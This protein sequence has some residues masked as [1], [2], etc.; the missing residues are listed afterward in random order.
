MLVD[1][2]DPVIGP[3]EFVSHVRAIERT[4][5]SGFSFA[6][7]RDDDGAPTALQGVRFCCGLVDT[8]TVFGP[9]D[10]VAARYRDV[11]YDRVDGT[12]LWRVTGGALDVL[13]ELL[14]REPSI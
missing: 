4:L 6:F 13:E 11:D 8:Y 7:L 3:F 9:W 10:A 12:P 14:D 2:S 1:M 5:S